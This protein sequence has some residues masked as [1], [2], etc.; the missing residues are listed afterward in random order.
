MKPE[1]GRHAIRVLI[2]ED[3]KIVATDLARRLESLGYPIVGVAGRGEDAI[4][5]AFEEDPDIILNGR[6]P[7][8]RA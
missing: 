3:E 7:R 6:P 1:P 2:A 4:R 5:L 8:R